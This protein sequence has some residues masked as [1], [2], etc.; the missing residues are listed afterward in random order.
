MLR[1]PYIESTTVLSDKTVY[2]DVPGSPEE[3]SSMCTCTP[4]LIILSYLC[5]VYFHSYFIIM[6][7]R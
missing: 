5:T 1:D 7:L 2:T 3:C 6:C 4:V